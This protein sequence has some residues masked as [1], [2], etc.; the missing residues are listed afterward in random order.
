MDNKFYPDRLID[1]EATTASGND[2]ICIVTS[3]EITSTFD[4]DKFSIRYVT[5]SHRWGKHQP[6]QLLRENLEILRQGVHMDYLP[7]LFQEAVAVTKRLKYRYL[8]IDS[9]CIVQDDWRD[10]NIQASKMADIYS[11]SQVCIAASDTEDGNCS[12]LTPSG[13][14]KYKSYGIESYLGLGGDETFVRKA[15]HDHDWE[16][17]PMTKITTGRI[18]NSSLLS[19]RTWAFQELLLGKRVLRFLARDV[20]FHCGHGTRCAC[21]HYDYWCQP[22]PLESLMFN[23]ASLRLPWV[24]CDEMS[25]YPSGPSADK[26]APRDLW[27][28]LVEKYSGLEV[29]KGTD[30]LPALS[31]IAKS[32]LLVRPK[33]EEYFAGIWRTTF[34]RDLMWTRANPRVDF[35]ARP[36]AYRAPSWSWVSINER[37]CFTQCD[38]CDV[39]LTDL[40]SAD[41]N[42]KGDNV[43]GEIVGGHA[44]LRGPVIAE[45]NMFKTFTA[46]Y[47]GYRIWTLTINIGNV[48]W[49]GMRVSLDC[50]RETY[51]WKTRSSAISFA[52][53]K[54]LKGTDSDCG[55]LDCKIFLA[56]QKVHPHNAPGSM[57]H[58]CPFFNLLLLAYVPSERS[59]IALIL[60]EVSGSPHELER[61]G[62]CKLWLEKSTNDGKILSLDEEAREFENTL[63]G[64]RSLPKK[65][66]KL[67]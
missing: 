64:L 11:N 10:W 55:C 27:H 61:I 20:E 50:L 3:D 25:P 59:L 39:L 18:K 60:T 52:N 19:K 6:A 26:W 43:F 47:S 48:L 62:L 56:L 51:P 28:V 32:C 24:G 38:L 34:V 46:G 41:S 7:R 53:P 1:L 42:L 33:G 58:Q 54:G 29:T 40:V 30:V 12:F 17:D 49:E 4:P 16:Y 45:R 15:I 5:L 35:K 57:K 65:T 2:A 8:W 31:G 37:V 63:R 13:V 44:L 23:V 9:L 66:V 22:K 36:V 67:I 14:E 21:R